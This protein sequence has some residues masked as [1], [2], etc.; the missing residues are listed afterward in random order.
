MSKYNVTTKIASRWFKIFTLTDKGDK[1]IVSFSEKSLAELVSLYQNNELT[2]REFNGQR[3]LNVG[4][5]EDNYNKQNF[6]QNN[7]QNNYKNFND[8]KDDDIPF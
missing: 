2:F 8:T 3:Y 1:K 5:F 7:V 6:V 4:V